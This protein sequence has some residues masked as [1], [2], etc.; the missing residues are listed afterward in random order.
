[1]PVRLIAFACALVAASAHAA[2]NF[3]ARPV[4]LLVPQAAGGSS[5]DGSSAAAER[6]ADVTP[7]LPAS[8]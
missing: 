4:R 6:S 7:T 3:P 2:E 8:D 1:M 5:E